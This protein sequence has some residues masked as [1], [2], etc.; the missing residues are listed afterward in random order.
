MENKIINKIL[1]LSI[2]ILIIILNRTQNKLLNN[3][4][5]K[6]IQIK[7]QVWLRQHKI[8]KI[9]SNLKIKK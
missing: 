4:N 1:L 2:K 3:Q 6:I 5:N 7:Y 8:I 9:K